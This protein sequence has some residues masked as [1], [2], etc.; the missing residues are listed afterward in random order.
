[1][2]NVLF[3]LC[4][5]TAQAGLFAQHR[6]EKL[7]E[8]DSVFKVPE[9]VLY[10]A[11]R[12]VLYVTNIDGKD[13]WGADGAGSVGMMKPDGTVIAEEWVSGMDAPKGMALFNDWLYVADLGR[14]HVI[15]TATGIT[16]I[17][18]RIPGA[19]GLNDV[20]A[21]KN[22]VVY[23]TDSRG[24]KVFRVEKGKAEVYL[25]QLK[26]PN[27]ILTSDDGL[28]LLDAGA[29]YRVGEDKVLHKLAEG[30]SGGTDGV[31]KING[32]DFMVSCWAGAIWYVQ[33]DGTKELLLDGAKDK[34]N[35]ADIGFDAASNIVYVPT[36]WKNTVIAFRVKER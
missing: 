33:A 27:G 16:D 21:D 3:I 9:S 31:E 19:E 25:D 30:M 26:G 29:L 5:L 14:L 6:L 34:V 22:G 8:T 35:T 1:M 20:T 18:I 32:K 13:P 15:N 28:Y 17:T 2:K 10:D 12:Q 4:L 7:W 23:V 36:F 11:S 24:K